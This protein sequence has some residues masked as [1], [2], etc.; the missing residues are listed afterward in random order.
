MATS[1]LPGQ[2]V[3]V[4]MLLKSTEKTVHCVWGAHFTCSESAPSHCWLGYALSW[5]VR[6]SQTTSRGFTVYLSCVWCC[7]EPQLSLFPLDRL[8]GF[9]ALIW[10]WCD[11]ALCSAYFFCSCPFRPLSVQKHSSMPVA[12]LCY[13]VGDTT[14]ILEVRNSWWIKTDD[15]RVRGYTSAQ[16]L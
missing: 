5:T 15:S 14:F 9:T 6:V 16:W 13:S 4:S 11:T 10:Y 1:V 12:A 3:F 8:L 2:P 7:V